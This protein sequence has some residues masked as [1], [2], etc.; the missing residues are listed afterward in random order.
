MKKNNP[1]KSYG[2]ITVAVIALFLVAALIAGIFGVLKSTDVPA[3]LGSVSSSESG[4]E[5]VVESFPPESEIEQPQPGELMPEDFRGLWLSDHDISE[6]TDID[7]LITPSKDT[8]ITVVIA[9]VSADT[10]ISRLT[11]ISA[12][13]KDNEMSLIINL[14]SL[15]ENKDEL[16][17]ILSA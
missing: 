4:Y 12:V 14:V 3:G 8:G 2:K 9:D 13:S 15:P 6:S 11:E 17:P 16:I 10:D 5:S 7:G 1:S